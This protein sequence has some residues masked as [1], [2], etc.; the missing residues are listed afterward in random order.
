MTLNIKNEE[1]FYI[2][3][4]DYKDSIYKIFEYESENLDINFNYYNNLFKIAFNII[5]NEMFIVYSP[6]LL[7]IGFYL[8]QKIINYCKKNNLKITISSLLFPSYSNLIKSLNLSLKN[9]KTLLFF[10]F[11]EYIFSTEYY[12]LFLEKII[13]DFSNKTYLNYKKEKTKENFFHRT[14]E[15]SNNN[16]KNKLIII[17]FIINKK[18]DLNKKYKN[19][20]INKIIQNNKVYI[21]S[22]IKENFTF[23]FTNNL[24]E[25]D[26]LEKFTD[27][28]IIE[29]YKEHLNYLEKKP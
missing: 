7:E 28:S 3:L 15:T 8:N 13:N 12:F 14:Y 5:D 10:I 6:L 24:L 11:F 21:N 20:K 4:F 25:E 19:H 2:I 22:F 1:N 23:I 27:S 16:F 17:F 29:L 26:I 18:N 9:S